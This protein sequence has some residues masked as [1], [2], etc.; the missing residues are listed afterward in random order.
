MLATLNE[1]KLLQ[2]L[3]HP[4]IIKIYHSFIDNS[5]FYILMEYA[6]GGDLYKIAEKNAKE[7]TRFPEKQLWK[8]TYEILLA[9]RYLHNNCVIHCD[10]KASNIF[11]TKKKRIKIGDF[12]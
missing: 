7:K 1:V 6:S 2:D 5:Y 10:I 12:G 4:H 9:L 3:K 8:W 11:I